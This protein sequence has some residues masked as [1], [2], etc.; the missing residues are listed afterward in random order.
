MNDHLVT[1]Q[2]H[3]AVPLPREIVFLGGAPGAGKGANSQYIANL[4]HFDAPTIVISSLL[5]TPTCKKLKDRGSMVD[6][7]FVYRVLMQELQKPIYRQG[8]VVDGFPRTEKQFEQLIRLEKELSDSRSSTHMCFVMLH[9]DEEISIQRQQAR[10]S[11][12]VRLMSSA[13]GGGSAL[14][15]TH[16]VRVTDL[17]VAASKARYSLFLE[18]LHAVRKLSEHS[19]PLVVVDASFSLDEVRANIASRMAALPF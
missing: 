6:D 17:N 16:E 15:L 18:H 9:V 3:Q 5:N 8:V 10:G 19:I 13:A 4:R 12:A 11:E 7:D 14:Q 2:S 1:L